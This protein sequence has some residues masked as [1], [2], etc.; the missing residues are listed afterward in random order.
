[1][2]NRKNALANAILS[3]AIF[4]K[5]KESGF[6]GSTYSENIFE[7]QKNNCKIPLNTKRRGPFTGPR[8]YVYSVFGSRQFPS[9]STFGSVYHFFITLSSLVCFIATFDSYRF[10]M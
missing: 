7:I 2:K 8:R 9:V 3:H 4:H 10:A 1:M 6:F 5:V